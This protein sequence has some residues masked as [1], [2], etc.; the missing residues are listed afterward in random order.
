MSSAILT[1]VEICE[2]ETCYS[3]RMNGSDMTRI[4][5]KFTSFVH[6]TQKIE[7]MLVVNFQIS[8]KD[9]DYF[10]FQLNRST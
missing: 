5:F 8:R 10:C 2:F 3:L 9:G 4:V 6:L 1:R 7:Q